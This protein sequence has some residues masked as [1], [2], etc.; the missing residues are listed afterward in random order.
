V[1][2][3]IYKAI[4]RLQLK[5]QFLKSLP[6]VYRK[7]FCVANEEGFINKPKHVANTIF[8]L[9]LIKFYLTKKLC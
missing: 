8:S 6:I 1:F 3:L 4:F 2:L 5:R 9:P 7:F